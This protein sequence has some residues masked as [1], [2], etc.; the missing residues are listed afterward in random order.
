MVNSSQILKV[1]MVY[2]ICSSISTLQTTV[3]EFDMWFIV[4]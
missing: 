1:N 4:K 2:D 3:D